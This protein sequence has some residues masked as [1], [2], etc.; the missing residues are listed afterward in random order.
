MNSKTGYLRSTLIGG[1]LY[2]VPIVVLIVILGKALEI[3]HR[4]A[5]PI[6]RLVDAA[7]LGHILPPQ[8]VA[9]LLLVL[10]CLAVGRLAQS[11]IGKRIGSRLD[12]TL[13]N[14]PGYSFYRGIGESIAGAEPSGLQQPVMVSIE[15][16]WQLGMVVDKLEDGLLAVYI[17]SVPEGRSGSLYFMDPDRVRPL[18]INLKTGFKVLRRMGVGS[19]ELLKRES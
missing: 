19:G 7:G 9:L 13:G 15:D 4:I 10:F 17:P 12:D 14:L 6:V 18:S 2:L 5:Q 8:V 11:G 1:V 16:A 3:A